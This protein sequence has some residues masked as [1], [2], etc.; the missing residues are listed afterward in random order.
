MKAYVLLVLISGFCPLMAQQPAEK[1]A[2]VEIGEKELTLNQP[3]IL[4]VVVRN[5]SSRPSVQFPELPGLEKRSASAT[6]TTNV[7]NG[8]T[9]LIQTISQQYFAK[10][11]GKYTL[12]PFEVTVDG[13]KIKGEGV[14]LTFNKTD[15]QEIST[16]NTAGEPEI[17]SSTEDIAAGSIFLSVKV[18]KPIVYVREGFSVRLALYVAKN[19]PI[20]MEFYRLDAQLQSI[21]KKLR[22]A[23]CWEENVGIEEIIQREVNIGGKKFTEYQMYQA[24]FFPI[25]L[26]SV[27]FP[28]VK[29]DML[30]WETLA[31]GKRSKTVETFSTR[32][33]RVLVKPLPPHPQKDQIAVGEYRLRE[34]VTRESVHSG[35]SLRYL[36]TIEGEGNIAT[37][38]PPEV[39]NSKAFDFYPP[40]VSQTVQRSYEKVS[41][42]KTFD[43]YLVARQKGDFPL[44][45]FF[46]W[47]YFDPIKT[48]YDTLRSAETIEVAGENLQA[49]SLTG[50]G[51]DPVYGNIV[52]MA[53]TDT[54]IDYQEIIR[55]LTNAV[56]LVLLGA[57]IWIFRK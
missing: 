51:K 20:E 56:V 4:S 53:T 39:T 21:L 57:M 22:P 38:T 47:I 7:V 50:E 42:E 55:N 19:A 48:R 44:G 34:N 12:V 30:F 29:L 25:T 16:E 28:A 24:V 17:I 18:S 2:S 26:Q 45:K 8:M 9:V 23:T 36:F 10:Q 37:L 32:H 11:A 46:Q 5:S 49:A 35:E 52:D 33:V 43:Y 3:F 13:T 14:T 1:S 6:T 40:D 54:Y 41:G 31:D 15:S 27:S